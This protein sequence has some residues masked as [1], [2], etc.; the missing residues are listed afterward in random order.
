[1]VAKKPLTLLLSAVTVTALAAPALAAGGGSAIGVSYVTV[2][3]T[4][5]FS[6][7]K[8]DGSGLTGFPFVDGTL[9]L[10]F[11]T[12][13]A[14]ANR[15]LNGSG[16]QVSAT[17]SNLYLQTSTG[18]DWSTYI[19]S[20]AL[21]LGYG[22]NPLAATAL[23]PVSPDV[24]LA[25][26][27]ATCT[28]PAIA[29]ALGY[30]VTS[31]ATA[32]LSLGNT[33]LINLCNALTTLAGAPLNTVTKVATQAV[34]V[35]TALAGSLTSLPYALTGA[36]EIG[37]FT[38]PAYSGQLGSGEPTQAGVATAK[39]I[40]TG[41]SLVGTAGSLTGLLA[42]LTTKVQ[43]TLSGLPLV[44]DTGAPALL[45]LS[46]AETALNA[47]QP[48]VASAI[49]ALTATQAAALINQLTATVQ[50]VTG[51]DLSTVTGNED[52]FPVLTA[53]PAA[54]KAGTYDGT[55]VVNFIECSNVC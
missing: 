39:R 20:S 34:D 8:A 13:V 46:Q 26:T 3:G 49:T 37:A 55:M 10:P 6:V 11:R 31:L 48:T 51:V 53:T 36:Q 35:S 54:S 18:H 23:L 27:L 4:R 52:A 25:G 21:S 29:T 30:T 7:T 33:S 17:M 28:S 40:M 24:A 14:D 43:T 22:A 50:A 19:P 38:S 16:Y 47:V 42:A 15:L 41:T 44:S 12:R 32:L 5:Q 45:T 1:M 9:S 2:D